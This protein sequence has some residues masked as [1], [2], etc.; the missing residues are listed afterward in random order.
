VVVVVVIV[1][2]DVVVVELLFLLLFSSYSLHSSST[3]ILSTNSS[4]CFIYYLFCVWYR[5]TA[6]VNIVASAPAD[7]QIRVSWDK[8]SELYPMQNTTG[9]ITIDTWN[10]TKVVNVTYTITCYS[11]DAPSVTGTTADTSY[12]FNKVRVH[13]YVSDSLRDMNVFKSN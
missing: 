11:A 2:F 10:Q 5:S 6:P 7:F 8:P 1:N 3:C 12:T 4:S 9:N 13:H